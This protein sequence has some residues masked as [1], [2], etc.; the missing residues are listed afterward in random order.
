M[1]VK[2]RIQLEEL[3]IQRNIDQP[4]S[5]MNRDEMLKI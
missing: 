5:H 3:E 1:I 4:V 2:K